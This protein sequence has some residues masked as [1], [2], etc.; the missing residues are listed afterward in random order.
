MQPVLVCGV[1]QFLDNDLWTPKAFSRDFGE[2]AFI[3]MQGSSRCT[4]SSF[5][6][7]LIPAWSVGYSG[8][9][10]EHQEREKETDET[11]FHH[12]C[13]I[14]ERWVTYHLEHPILPPK[15]SL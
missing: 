5:L 15:I 10:T 14:S 7:L 2:C 3:R 4:F 12:C 9:L 13:F 8:H 11:V 1:D 6:L